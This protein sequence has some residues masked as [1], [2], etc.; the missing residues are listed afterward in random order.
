M[1]SKLNL[2]VIVIMLL[3]A[4]TA[5][6]QYESMLYPNGSNDCG[7]QGL[8]NAP[9]NPIDNFGGW[10]KPS[11]SDIGGA[12]SGL[13]YFPVL[14][15]FVQF[16]NEADINGYGWHT[17]TAPD[18]MDSV[19]SRQRVNNPNWW[20]SYN[21]FQLSDYFQ[22]FSRGKLHI[23]G[24]CEPVILSNNEQWYRTYDSLYGGVSAIINKEIYDTLIN[25]GSKIYWPDYDKWTTTSEGNFS[26]GRDGSVDMMYLIHRHEG[27]GVLG[28]GAEGFM[29]QKSASGE[30]EGRYKVYDD[31]YGTVINISSGSDSA[32]YNKSTG[33][34]VSGRSGVTTREL[35][36][37]VAVH[38]HG[39]YLFGT[40][41]ITYSKMAK[42]AGREFSF[43]PWESIKLD[44]I[45][46]KII[47]YSNTLNVLGDISSRYGSAGEEGNIIKVPVD[48]T[49]N[50][51]FLIANRQKISD[52]DR[53][54]AGDTVPNEKGYLK[55]INPEYGK[56][57]YIYHISYGFSYPFFDA[58]HMDMECADGLWN[59]VQ[60][61]TAS[62]DWSPTEVHPVFRRNTVSYNQDNPTTI[63]TANNRDGLSLSMVGT[64]PAGSVEM[65]TWYS[66]GKPHQYNPKVNGTDRYYTND[67]G[68]WYSYE[69]SGDRWD[70]WRPAYNEVFSPYSSPNT[71]KW[72]NDSSGIF[73]Y[74][75]GMSGSDANI[76]I[77]RV[78]YGGFNSEWDILGVTPPSKP[79]GIK[80][81][82]YYP[83]NSWCVPKITWNHNMEP[84]M[85][86]G[87]KAKYKRYRVYRSLAA[88]MNYV[89]DENNYILID[90]VDISTN[91]TPYY[92]DFSIKEHE[93]AEL[94]QRPPYG[95]EF[96]VRYKVVAVDLFETPSVLSDFTSTTG[97]NEDGGIPIGGGEDNLIFNPETPKQFNLSQN[98]PN[99]FNPV[100]KINFALPKQGFVTL[101][102][103]DITGREFQTLVSEVKQSGY[104][105]VDFNGSSL[106]SGVYFYKIQSGDF[107]SVKRMVLIK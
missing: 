73:I 2:L 80:H 62:P 82:Y 19:I 14:V 60:Y 43:S 36:L 77:Y 86:R 79:M 25:R 26:W 39:H 105:S 20:D 61:G 40:G 44:Y 32:G 29:P 97:I 34:V 101:K 41:H 66:I 94:D 67:L 10:Y 93:C 51:F 22:E 56:G 106:S 4:S 5:K 9:L 107:V 23:T 99:P 75:S 71:N 52:W 100:T 28:V 78:G 69:V 1:N 81:E 98:Y 103:Y 3:T 89:P 38:E 48:E 96:P 31:G 35:F 102:I 33:I 15:V 17:G 59:W 24:Q 30:V 27:L 87:T 84:D 50:E 8:S 83:E 49:G 21:A 72:G 90:S 95:I 55:N 63:T 58:R 64:R 74:L 92:I 47:N 12:P 65:G 91:I 85:E 54:M 6:S 45:H 57:V 68:S 7:T 16:A 42:G 37:E 76:K 11:R 104:Y 13:D 53:R 70:A 46:P 88:N 18:W